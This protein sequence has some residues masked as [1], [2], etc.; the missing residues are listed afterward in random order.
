MDFDKQRRG[1]I[2]RQRFVRALNARCPQLNLSETRLICKAFAT[3]KTD[4]GDNVNYMWFI[5]AVDSADDVLGNLGQISRGA[6]MP[7]SYTKSNL[8][9]PPAARSRVLVKTDIK[10]LLLKL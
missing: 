4:S 9:K 6:A 8:E 1:Y 2:T 7:K 10:T 3:P 5:K